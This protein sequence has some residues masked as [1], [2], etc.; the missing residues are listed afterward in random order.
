MEGTKQL[1]HDAAYHSITSPIIYIY[2]YIYIYNHLK[3][4]VIQY[5]LQQVTTLCMVSDLKKMHKVM[6]HPKATSTTIGMNIR[7]N[8]IF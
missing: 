4:I 6:C 7:C 2:I 3:N 1:D 5:H 8:E